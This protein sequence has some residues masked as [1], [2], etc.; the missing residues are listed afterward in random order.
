MHGQNISSML[1][2]ITLGDSDRNMDR[3]NVALIGAGRMG[4][5]HGPNAG[6]H[7]GLRLKYV[8]DPRADA[9]ERL[10]APFGAAHASLDTVLADTEIGGILICSSTDQHLDHALAAVAAGKTVFCEKPL[11]LDLDKVIAAGPRLA[12][13]RL[14]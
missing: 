8:V 11:D 10:A 7:P 1:F 9:A 12:K 3:I 5:I 14:V 4:S 2:R 6:R 13:A